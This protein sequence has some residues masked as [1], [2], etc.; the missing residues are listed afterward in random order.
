MTAT[1]SPSPVPSF[2]ADLAA[3]LTPQSLAWRTA[4]DF[5]GFLLAG[6]ALL[7]QVAH[8]TVGAG[9]SEHS[10]FKA[11]PWGRLIRTLDF[12]NGV[13]YSDD[14]EGV[15][16]RMRAMHKTIKGVKPDGT[17]YHAMEPEAFTWVHATLVE[18]M[19]AANQAF[20]KPL[21]LTELDRFYYEMRGVGALY[22]VR[23]R[24]LP[25]DWK[26]FME[27]YD[28]M[29]DER[30]ENNDSVQD[31]LA[32]MGK[33]ARPHRAIP[34]GLWNFASRPASKAL[35]VGTMGLIPARLRERF[36]AEWTAGDE[37][38]LRVM[39]ST[40]RGVD[41]VVPDSLRVF[42]P[43]YLQLRGRY[44]PPVLGPGAQ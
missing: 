43:R 41:P 6:R 22:G 34:K 26:G 37:R 13:L 19:A 8:P 7:L 15:A 25:E 11:D 44:G 21:T 14:A 28:W 24:D 12:L 1:E 9:V 17:R 39:K 4:S 23:E 35:W 33:P 27:Y 29:I 3:A 36:G 10:D 5:R 20:A 38:I 40:A 31:V 32:T 16:A 30:L 18:S 42:G 2:S